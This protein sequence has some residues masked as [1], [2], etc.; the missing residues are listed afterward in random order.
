MIDWQKLRNLIANTPIGFAISS[1]MI[2]VELSIMKL[3]HDKHTITLLKEIIYED[4]PFLLKPSEL[5]TLYSLA[6]YQKD[7]EGDYAEVGVFKGATAKAICEAKKDKPLYLF[8]T[9]DGLPEVSS[10]DS[11]MF[12]EKQFV[13]SEDLVKKKLSKY[14][15]V[16]IVKGLFPQSG[17]NVSNN[18]FSFVHLDVDL[19][20]STKD[21]LEFFYC[22][23]S[24]D[25]ILISHDYHADGV[26]KAFNEFFEDKSEKVIKLPMSQCMFVKK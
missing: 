10:F 9:F 18:K 8:D 5:F 21:C 22:R 23:M 14:S 2:F 3:Y 19:Y 12:K 20:R 25:A 7:V 17:T 13:S 11:G 16:N 15:N 26:R 24:K 1:L 4:S 6:N